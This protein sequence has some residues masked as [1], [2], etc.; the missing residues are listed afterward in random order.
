MLLQKIELLPPSLDRAYASVSYT[1][2][3]IIVMHFLSDA[4]PDTLVNRG[5]LRHL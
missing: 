2:R 4:A 3:C 1:D 5:D